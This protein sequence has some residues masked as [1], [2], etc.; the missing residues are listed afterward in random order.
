[1]QRETGETSGEDQQGTGTPVLRR[2]LLALSMFLSVAAFGF[3]EPFVP[4]YL[5]LSGLARGEI[6]LVSGIGTGLALLIQPLLGRLSDRLDARRPLMLA[7]ALTAGAAYL[8][9][10]SAEGLLPF[11]LLTALGVNGVMYLNTANAV[12]V[13]RL[14]AQEGPKSARAGTFAAY[15][16]WGSVGYVVVSL[17]SGWVLGRA[18]GAQ[19][20]ASRAAVAP[21]FLYGPLLF[22]L[23]A[24]LIGFLPDPKRRAAPTG[25]ES[26]ALPAGPRQ[27]GLRNLDQFL[28]AYFFYVFAYAGCAAYISL[29]LRSLGA[30]PFWITGV[31][32][33]GVICE[34]L[35][36]SQAGRICDRFG[37]RPLLAVAFLAMPVRLALYVVAGS[38][39]GVLWV[40]LLHGV[41][42]GIM[43]TVA[44]TF[45]S[46]LC[47]EAERGAMQARLT[48]TSGIAAATGPAVGGWIAQQWGLPWT[49]GVM[50]CVAAV[51]AALFVWKVRETHRTPARLHRLC[52]AGL[53]P[54]FGVLCVPAVRLSRCFPAL[55]H[56][57]RSS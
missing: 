45:V 36:M 33:S 12:L 15:R 50:A 10:R 42:F 30:T 37:R 29:H 2:C 6:G 56:R 26:D 43:A 47:S 23:V 27:V 22:L 24:V 17:L 25:G 32:A 55:P 52:P 41:N 18:L 3:L 21:I 19:A 16:I 13:S 1:M 57:R 7:A 40:Q 28:R 11:V 9:Y 38:P 31:F 46:D 34:V 20:L 39:L 44:I 49:F 51:G 35:V 54:L 4:L 5:E 53:R 8:S 48:A 14:A